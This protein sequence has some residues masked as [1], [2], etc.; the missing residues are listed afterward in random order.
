MQSNALQPI[1]QKQRIV[2]I[3]VLRGWAL[4]GVALMNYVDYFYMGMDWSKFKPDLLTNI[5]MTVGNIFFAAK[6]WT[7][8]SFLFGYGFSVLMQNVEAKGINPTQF[9]A[10]RMFWLF[11]LALINSAFFWGDIL[12]DY[13]VMG[14]VILMFHRCRARTAFIISLVLLFITPAVAAYVSSLARPGGMDLLKPYFYLFESS[15]P[16]KVLWFGLLGTYLYEIVSLNYLI[17]VHVIML[18]LFFFGMAAQK[19]GFLAHIHDNRKYVKRIFW[20]SLGAVLLIIALFMITQ[21]LN[22][23]W[24]KYYNP[25]YFI[26]IGSML[27][28]ASSICWFFISGKLKAF[29]RS[30]Q[31]IGKMTLTNYMTQNALALLLFSGIGLNFSLKNRIHYGYYL[32]FALV[33]YIIQVFISKWWLKRYQF[34]PIEWVWRQLSYAKR[35][36]IRKQETV[37]ETGKENE[38][39]TG[40][41]PTGEKADY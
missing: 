29:F 25:F 19:S 20:I 17:T 27:F 33:I 22:W 21:K 6:S 2:I 4:L 13:A 37:A 9:F 41:E 12:K 40:N 5:L 39:T 34:G 18:S 36:P 26:I 30:M 32:L 16:I 31:A 28:I 1:P 8:L 38:I 14:M 24:T 23:T 10:R 7:L 35:F 11:I 3:D 15:N